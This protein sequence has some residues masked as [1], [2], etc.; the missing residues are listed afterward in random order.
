MKSQ[1]AV[2][3]WSTKEHEIY[4]LFYVL[5]VY[6]QV[7]YGTVLLWHMGMLKF[8]GILYI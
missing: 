6:N 8:W 7:Q 4:I 3:N 2:R 1:Y 5:F